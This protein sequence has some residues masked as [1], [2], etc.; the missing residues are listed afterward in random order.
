MQ[1]AR[2]SLR[3]SINPPAFFLST[4]ARSTSTF[5][6]GG[7]VKW[8]LGGPGVGYLYVRRDLWPTLRPAMTGWQAHR[9]P[10]AFAGG[11]IDFADDAMR[12]LSGTPNIPALY[13]ACSG[14]EIV[15]EIGVSAIRERSIE[16]TQRLIAN[17]DNAGVPVHSQRDP[18]R[19]GG[20]VVFN[21]PDER[22]AAIVAELDRRG[23][24]VDHR[25]GAG[26]RVAPH[27]YSTEAEVD[28]T[29]AEL[30][31]VLHSVTSH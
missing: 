23:I 17:A 9:A 22:G 12:F 16:L 20:L 2:S 28:Y 15:N 4:F 1:L 6:T 19:R 14:Y 30:A 27:F 18:A 24:V 11:A 25:P 31:D 8:L 21:V 10:F 13:A 26:I 29:I 3:T 5:A 7:S